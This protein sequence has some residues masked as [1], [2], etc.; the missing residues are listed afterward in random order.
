MSNVDNV[1]TTTTNTIV[2]NANAAVSIGRWSNLAIITPFLSLLTFTDEDNFPQDLAK[3][4]IAQALNHFGVA[5]DVGI[6]GD[7][8]PSRTVGT[9]RAVGGGGVA[10]VGRWDGPQRIHQCHRRQD[11]HRD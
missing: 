5:L 1:T 4:S 6:F 3:A 10:V 2:A 11:K 7:R 9:N 8:R